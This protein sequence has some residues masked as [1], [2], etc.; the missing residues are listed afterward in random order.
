MRSRSYT[1]VRHTWSPTVIPTFP[2][3]HPCSSR[4]KRCGPPHPWCSRQGPSDGGAG[5]QSARRRSGPPGGPAERI[6]P[7]GGPRCSSTVG[8]AT[9]L[10]PAGYAKL[11]ATLGHGLKQINRRL[12]S[13]GNASWKPTSFVDRVRASG[14]IPSCR[15]RGSL[16]AFDALSR[17]ASRSRGVLAVH[18]A[19]CTQ[20]LRPH[21]VEQ[22]LGS[23][24]QVED[25]RLKPTRSV[26]DDGAAAAP[27]SNRPRQR[28][29]PL[30]HRRRD[31]TRPVARPLEGSSRGDFWHNH[32]AK[33]PTL[34]V[35]IAPRDRLETGGLLGGAHRSLMSDIF[36]DSRFFL[37]WKSLSLVAPQTSAQQSS[38][39]RGSRRDW[40]RFQ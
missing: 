25:M 35:R 13:T 5:P 12:P 24:D 32:L 15:P 28:L 3:R 4:R 31:T 16:H 14:S 34:A 17:S 7:A 1:P 2:W 36:L 6:E 38:A 21:E 8:G 30:V 27:A 40:K 10:W 18:V 23:Y 20:A 26:D 33:P 19:A 29:L 37:P 9:R 39:A 22:A 11:R